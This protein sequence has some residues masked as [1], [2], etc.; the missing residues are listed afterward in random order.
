MMVRMVVNP[1]SGYGYY[2]YHNI[3]V[4]VGKMRNQ[5]YSRLWNDVRLVLRLAAT[6]KSRKILFHAPGAEVWKSLGEALAVAVISV[7]EG[8]LPAAGEGDLWVIRGELKPRG[9]VASI[10]NRGGAVIAI[11]PSEEVREEVEGFRGKGLLLTGRRISLA[12]PN[13]DMKFTSYTMR[14]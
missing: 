1:R 14:F 10:L 5:S 11:D 12:I 7:E 8:K 9:A 4:A 2:G 3:D 13:R 6:L